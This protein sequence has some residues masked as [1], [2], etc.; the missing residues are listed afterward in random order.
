MHP[1]GKP[2]RLACDGTRRGRRGAG[3][4]CYQPDTGERDHCPRQAASEAARR[5]K[6]DNA[7]ENHDGQ[8]R[9][10]CCDRVAT[11]RFPNRRQRW[12]S[13]READPTAPGREQRQAT[14]QQTAEHRGDEA[15]AVA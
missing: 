6:R 8:W 13:H 15:G 3:G 7:G 11:R 9:H 4:T 14:G 2:R 10:D 1:A 5:G 12:L